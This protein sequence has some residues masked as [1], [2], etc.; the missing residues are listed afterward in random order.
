MT[1]I[2]REIRHAIAPKGVLRVALNHANRVLVTRDQEGSA[3][4]ISVDLARALAGRLHLPLTFIHRDRAVDVS[5]AAQADVY[6]IC[7]LA[8]DP[9]RARTIHFTAPYAQIEGAYLVGPQCDTRDAHTLIDE[10]HK[11]GTVEG[12]AYTLDLARKPGS[13]YLVHFSDIRAALDALDDDAVAA[14]AGIRAVLEREAADRAGA[15]VVDPSFMQIR[16]AMGMPA[17]RPAAARFLDFFVA[18]MLRLGRVGEILE[19][20]G[21]SAGRAVSPD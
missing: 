8:V 4:G 16:Q 10:G 2:T 12:S 13:E 1:E 18:D 9:D 3:Q 11:V 15:R 14:V 19:R 21:V 17:G 6:D 7:F 5:T 20:H